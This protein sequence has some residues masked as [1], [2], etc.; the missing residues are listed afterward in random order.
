MKQFRKQPQDH[1]DYDV[2]LDD[3]MADGDEIIS[4]QVEAPDGIEITQTG[5]SPSRVKIWIAGGTSGQSY[6]FSPLIFTQ[7]RIKEVDFLVIVTEM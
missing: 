4:V 5:I 7:S 3:W 2:I 1:L 6:K